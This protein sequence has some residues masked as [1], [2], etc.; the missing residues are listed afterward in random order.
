MIQQVARQPIRPG[1]LVLALLTEAWKDG[2]SPVRH[3]SADTCIF[4]DN[5]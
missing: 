4:S 2:M 3:A 5:R 1:T